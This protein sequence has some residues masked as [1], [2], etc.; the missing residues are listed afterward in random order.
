MALSYAHSLDPTLG[1]KRFFIL[2]PWL[3]NLPM[4]LWRWTL[5]L[6][7]TLCSCVCFCCVQPSGFLNSL[8]KNPK[9]RQIIYF[10][11]SKFLNFVCSMCQQRAQSVGR[12]GCPSGFSVC[13]VCVFFL[14]PSSSFSLFVLPLFLGLS[15]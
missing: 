15:L 2:G 7:L 1:P 13:V 6:S 11:V 3:V 9:K 5:S 10:S 14:P 4:V 12:S 8:K